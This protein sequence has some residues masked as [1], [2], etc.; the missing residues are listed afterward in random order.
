MRRYSF[1]VI[2]VFATGLLYLLWWNSSL[3]SQ[4]DYQLLDRSSR[5]FPSDHT[6]DHTVVVEIDDKSLK[7]FGQWPWPRMITA[8]LIHRLGMAQPQSVALDVVFSE[9]DRSSPKILENFYRDFF[10]LNVTITGIP[11]ALSDNDQLLAQSFTEAKIILP[12]FSDASQE[13]KECLFP[14][15]HPI[16][17]PIDRDALYTIDALVCSLPL[18]QKYAYAIGHI[19]AGA[20]S[21]GVLRRINMVVRYRDEVIPTLGAAALVDKPV[22]YGESGSSK[23]MSF[24]PYE[25][26]RK[27]SAYDVLSGTV[28][29]QIFKGKH[30]FV[31]TTALGL[32]TW[33]TLNNGTVLPGV[34]VHATVAENILNN[35]LKVQ[36]DGYKTF[37][38]LASFI[39][40]LVFLLWMEKTKRLRILSSS[41]VIFIGALALTM[42]G[43]NSGVYLSI[44]YF[45]VPLLSFL[46]ILSLLMFIIDYRN[47]KRFLQEIRRSSE[48]KELLKSEL[49]RSESEIE[50]QKAMLFQQSKLAAMG[51][52]I[53]NIA[54]QWRQ[55]LN[56]LAMI[57]QDSEFAY[58]GGRIDQKYVAKMTSDSMDQINFMS[59]TIDD[60]RNFV[61]PDQRNNPFDI[62]D[63]VAESI[64]LLE[65]MFRAHTI[66]VDVEYCSE[67]L[68]GFGS[69]SEFKQ[70]MINLLN[71]ARDA[72]VEHKVVNP[73]ITIRLFCDDMYGAITIQDNGGGID[74]SVIERIF[75]PYFSTKKEGKGSGIGLYISYSII[76]TKMGGTIE[77]SNVGNGTLFTLTIPLYKDPFVDEV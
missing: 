39:F 46:F 21:D 22:S 36:P 37:N 27:V 41:L 23:L 11:D 34:Y 28:D 58:R 66:R 51:E 72:L 17:N 10:D 19:H 65:G 30:L 40:A 67:P 77:A 8:E 48:Q 55:P 35:D 63:A 3:L 75:E 5:Y 44:G 43:L 60:F 50:Y 24:Y 13:A 16:V 70:V 12:V 56:N 1:W 62:N 54:H 4:L 25:S 6:P 14:S 32:D 20:D 2:S 38:I 45:I 7:A 76:R 64:Q 73:L 49:V 59:Q 47:T 42:I 9:Q 57:V 31:G 74:E 69:S 29:P 61:K 33:H 71:N 53:D 15:H 26:Y 18:Y 52:M 68:I